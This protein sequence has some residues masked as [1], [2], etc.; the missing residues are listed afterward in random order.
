MRP[1]RS[2]LSAST[3][4]RSLR[5]AFVASLPLLTLP[6]CDPAYSRSHRN[7]TPTTFEGPQY[8]DAQPL[9]LNVASISVVDRGQPGL[10]PGDLSG[11]A[12]NPPDQLLKQMAH[13]RLIAAGSGG[14]A[15]SPSTGPRS[16]M[17][18]VVYWTDS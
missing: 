16:C 4:R 17:N 6:L 1:N 10:V 9:N 11:R 3:L 15:S 2:P 12:P 13:D 8:G 14:K 5:A 7:D 18:P